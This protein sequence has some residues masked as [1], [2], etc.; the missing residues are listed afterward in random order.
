M[1]LVFDS[2]LTWGP[3][4]TNA[5]SKSAKALNALRLVVR[6]FSKKLLIQLGTSNF[7]SILYYN[8]QVWYINNL[9]QSL[10]NSILSASAKGSKTMPKKL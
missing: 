3:Q 9:K 5:P 7:Y 6:F 2:K 8:S 1:G 4:V 10:K